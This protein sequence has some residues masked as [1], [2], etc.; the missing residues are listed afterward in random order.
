MAAPG[1]CPAMRG[2]KESEPSGVP[3]V[4]DLGAPTVQLSHTTVGV[5]AEGGASAAASQP[6]R[7]DCVGRYIII[8]QLGTGGMGVVFSA[9][10]PELDRCIAL[11]LVHVKFVS[12][13]QRARL[14]ARLLREAQALA[15]LSHPNVIAVHDVGTF[16]D[17]VFVAM[18]LVEG[19]TLG[20]V[21][22]EDRPSSARALRLFVAAGRGLAAAHA[23]GLVHRDFKPD[24]V[25]VAADGRVCVLDFGLARAAHDGNATPDPELEPAP[26]ASLSPTHDG[27]ATSEPRAERRPR[28]STPLSVASRLSPERRLLGTSLTAFGTVLGTPHYMAPE[29]L[30]GRAVDARTDIYALGALAYHL[31]CGRPPFAGDNPIAIGFAHLSEPVTPPH[32]LRRDVPAGLEAAIIAALAKAPEDRPA[33]A[34][35]FIDKAFGAAA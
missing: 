14:Q 16:N 28:G 34:R 25:A 19:R 23:A 15:K 7:G 8:E 31:V 22:R 4:V 29:Q 10:D 20:E 5:E 33:S 12:S 32:Q 9:Y 1:Y 26:P 17:D 30:R 24:N 6:G 27:N 13:E 21:L 18:E 35:A 3:T 2:G 11:K